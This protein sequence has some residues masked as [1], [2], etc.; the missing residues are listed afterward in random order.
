MARV[1]SNSLPTN[2]DPE[3]ALTF[4]VALEAIHSPEIPDKVTIGIHCKFTGRHM[5]LS[6]SLSDRNELVRQLLNLPADNAP[7]P[8]KTK[9]EKKRA[10]FE[11]IGKPGSTQLDMTTTPASLKIEDK[12]VVF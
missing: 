9:E 12:D 5:S 7:P 11:M 8:L 6:L 4:P 2:A 10:K 3:H 1:L